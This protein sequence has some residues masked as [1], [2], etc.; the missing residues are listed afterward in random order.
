LEDNN[1][2][3]PASP[4]IKPIS[5]T[6]IQDVPRTSS[7]SE[8]VAPMATP[9]E[10]QH[11]GSEGTFVFTEDPAL[12]PSLIQCLQDHRLLETI[13]DYSRVCYAKDARGYKPLTERVLTDAIGCFEDS[14]KDKEKLL[15]EER[16][17]RRLAE[18]RLANSELLVKF[19]RGD[20]TS[21]GVHGGQRPRERSPR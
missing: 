10:T 18:D 15:D 11:V 21:D 1:D 12:T 20:T 19:R 16:E 7:L 14:L 9:K 8:S 17:A 6:P 4:T 13:Q 3:T 2:E 5:D